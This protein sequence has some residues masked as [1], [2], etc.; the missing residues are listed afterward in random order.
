MNG[1]QNPDGLSTAGIISFC[2]AACER[3]RIFGFNSVRG[4]ATSRWWSMQKFMALLVLVQS[5]NGILRSFQTGFP[6]NGMLG[7]QQTLVTQK[8]IMM[9]VVMMG[10][11]MMLMMLLMLMMLKMLMLMTLMILM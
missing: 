7:R 4:P 10:M 3:L 8:K 9:V 11:L 2:M 6:L 1:K 5:V